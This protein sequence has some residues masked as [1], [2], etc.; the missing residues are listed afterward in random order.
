MTGILEGKTAI[1]TGAA[2][3]IGE[4]TTKLF[5]AEGARV[6]AADLPGAPLADVHADTPNVVLVEQDVTADGAGDALVARA[7]EEFGGVDILFNNAGTVGAGGEVETHDEAD[8]DFVIGLNLTS[9]YRLSKAAI[10][11]L[12]K[13]SAG[14]IV[15]V[16][17]VRSDFADA[18]ACA[19]TA[20]KHAVAGLTKVLAC[21]LGPHGG[22]ANF[23]QPGAIVTGITKPAFEMMP[24]FA[25]YWTAL[26]PTGRLGEASDIANAVMFLASDEASFVNG[27]GLYIDGGAT[28][29][30]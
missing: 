23:V 2:S 28:C 19:Y 5:A 11:E 9:V 10:P 13:S 27:I 17:S 30:N 16:G 7:V 14:R 15:N 24:Q 21:E 1:I 26:A 12:K 22:T 3:G 6:L 20:S 25:E 8:W 4:A 18:G 29:H